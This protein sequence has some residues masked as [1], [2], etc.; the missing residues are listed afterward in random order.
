M[1]IKLTPEG[2]APELKSKII[3]LCKTIV[4]KASIWIYGSRA[5]GD[6]TDRSDIDLA[7]DAKQPID[8]FIIAE[9][10]DVLE[11]A[12]ISYRFDV[13]DLNSISDQ[14]F[15]DAVKKEMVLWQT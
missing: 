9:L 1:E 14:K 7:L 5:R 2:L 12:N 15:K 13:I 11:A 4:P 6:Y 3:G 8:F 10:K